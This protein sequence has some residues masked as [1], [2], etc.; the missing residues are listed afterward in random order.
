VD[1]RVTPE[2]LGRL[3]DEQ[4]GALALYAAQWTDAADDCVQ[5]ALIELARQPVA[6]ASPLAWLYRVVRNRAISSFRSARRR[7]RR[8]A[9]ASRLRPRELDG[10]SAEPVFDAEELAAALEA[11]PEELREAVVART[12]G[13]L[14]FEQI[15]ALAGC[16]TSTAHRR[17]EAGLT[18]LRER[19]D[20]SCHN[21]TATN[22]QT[23]NTK[24][25]ARLRTS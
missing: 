25:A 18:A 9:L 17:Y 22:T 15:A 21:H 5:E 23:T 1:S 3:L 12:W 24:I 4:G 2:L 20:V 16:S 8:E 6:P 13:G 19:L 11:L 14:G 10:E 7:E